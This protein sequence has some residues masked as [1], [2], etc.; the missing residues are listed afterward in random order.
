MKPIYVH[1]E[2]CLRVLFYPDCTL[3]WC[4]WRSTS[5]LNFQTINCRSSLS[6]WFLGVLY[7]PGLQRLQK[8]T[9]RCAK[10]FS[11]RIR[12]YIKTHSDQMKN[13]VIHLCEIRQF[14]APFSYTW[15]LGLLILPL[16]VLHFEVVA[17]APKKISYVHSQEEELGLL[18]LL[19]E[20]L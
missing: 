15:N 14:C 17:L 9:P 16:E 8:K 7:S 20:V 10:V 13:S 18:I 1:N 12:S 6:I 11:W 5:E 2:V 19:L 4:I 3:G